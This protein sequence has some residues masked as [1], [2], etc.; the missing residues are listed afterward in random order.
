MKTRKV[1]KSKYLIPENG[2][3]GEDVGGG[4]CDKQIAE[5]IEA[6]S[7][8]EAEFRNGIGGENEG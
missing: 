5:N 3:F 7:I 4:R 1:K 6:L 8:I 2:T